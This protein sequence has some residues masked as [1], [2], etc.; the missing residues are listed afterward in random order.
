MNKTPTNA[1]ANT[2]AGRSIIVPCYNEEGGITETIN[3]LIDVVQSNGAPFEILA[4]DDGSDDATLKKLE[5]FGDSIE[6]IKN[7]KNLGYGASLK[8]GLLKAQ[9]DVICII[10]ADGTYPVD[11]VPGLYENVAK[12]GFDMAVG[13]RTGANVATSKLRIPAKYVLGKLSNYVAGQNIPDMNS[14]LRVFR[15]SIAMR[16]YPLF[17]DGFSFTT[18]ITLAMLTNGYDVKFVPTDYLHRVGKSKI[19]PIRDTLSFI[20]LILRISLYFSPLKVFIPLSLGL[21]LLALGWGLVS[22]FVFGQLA[23]VST[24]VLFV[25]ALQVGVLGMLAEMINLRLPRIH[26]NP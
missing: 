19:R 23:D 2:I 6:I 25:S 14:G 22:Y 4:V 20:Q 1:S 17:P 18:T 13:A 9:Y 3:S 26:E 21:F 15:R 12:D 16:M 10:D 24:L 5:E 8:R 11:S 7:E